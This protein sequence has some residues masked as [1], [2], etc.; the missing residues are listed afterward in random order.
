MTNAI[1]LTIV[2]FA[3]GCCAG[4]SRPASTALVG[5]IVSE[6]RAAAAYGLL[7]WAGNVGF[8]IASLLGG[9]I[10]TKSF[11]LLYLIDSATCMTALVLLVYGEWAHLL[12][13]HIV[14]VACGKIN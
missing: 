12:R 5:D 6:E 4:M 13:N 7:Y 8:L 11:L 1:L 2:V 3:I 9:F 10:A 14:R